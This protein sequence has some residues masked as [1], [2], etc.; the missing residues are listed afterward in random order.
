[1]DP[2]LYIGKS[3]PDKKASTSSKGTAQSIDKKPRVGEQRGGAY[4][5]RLQV[6]YT[7]R[8]K[9]SYRYFKTAEELERYM[10]WKSGDKAAKKQSK[11][12]HEGV[13]KLANKK[14][15]EDKESTGKTSTS[16]GKILSGPK[17][18]GTDREK[19]DSEV[20]KSLG[21]FI[22]RFET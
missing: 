7:K 13:A 2:L 16:V 3:G 18:I 17:V 6:G 8:G 4:V 22:W 20:K 15:Q 21:V 9:P 10:K 12:R 19:E 14:S 1:M 11:K 5:A